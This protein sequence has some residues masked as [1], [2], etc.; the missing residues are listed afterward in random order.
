LH[1]FRKVAWSSEQLSKLAEDHV[2]SHPMFNYV[3]L[4]LLKGKLI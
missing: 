3:L 1:P 4:L 2:F